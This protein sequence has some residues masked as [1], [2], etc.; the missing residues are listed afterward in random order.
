MIRRKVSTG[1]LR[2]SKSTSSLRSVAQVHAGSSSTQTAG[3][4]TS[5]LLSSQKNWTR[6]T[7][8]TLKSE[9]KRRGLSQSGNK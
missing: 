6:E 7:V 5:T 4:A 9:L 8:V 1:L 3:F 2:A